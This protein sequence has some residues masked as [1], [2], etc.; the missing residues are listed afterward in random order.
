M[1]DLDGPREIIS[2]QEARALGLKRYFT[3]K[4]CKHGHVAERYTSIGNCVECQAQNYRDW[5]PENVSGIVERNARWRADNP[6]KVAKHDRDKVIRRR[7]R[8]LDGFL[9][10]QRNR[11][12]RFR[13]RHPERIK[14]TSQEYYYSHREKIIAG[15]LEWT[16]THPEQARAKGSRKRAR[17]AA[18]P[19]SHT[20]EE[21]LALLEEQGGLCVGPGCGV[22]I[23]DT[24]TIDHKI[25]L[26]REE[27]SDDIGNIQLLCFACNASKRDRTMDEW[28]G[29]PVR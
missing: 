19:G 26:T 7:A 17:L 4:P 14:E 29:R 16:R 15:V 21:L 24:W 20:I 5:Y 27:T 25:P 3:G 1:A 11:N 9:Q 18:A 12:K 23:R 22:D 6:E 2:R 13:E 28:R 8:D 10:N